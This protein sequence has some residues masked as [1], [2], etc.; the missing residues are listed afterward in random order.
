MNRTQLYTYCKINN[1]KGC[2]KM[3]KVELMKIVKEH[4][5]KNIIKKQNIFNFHDDIFSSDKILENRINIYKANG[6][7][8]NRIVDWRFSLNN[9]HYDLE[10]YLK[11]IALDV[12]S[13]II[14]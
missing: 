3:G 2:A 7:W 10:N 6:A 8:N 12:E 4:Q 11:T 5:D 13:K 14:E 1:I 9:N